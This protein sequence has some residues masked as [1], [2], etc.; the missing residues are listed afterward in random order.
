M[1]RLGLSGFIAVSRDF[2]N[3]PDFRDGEM[4]Q[5]EAF[6]WML[7]EAA[8]KPR[9]KRI[10]TV[11]LELQRGQLAASTRFLAKAWGWSEPRV[12]RY[13]DM[14]K[15]RRTIDAATDA[16]VTV[17]TIRN[18]D[19]YQSAASGADAPGDEK[20]THH[21]RTTDANPEQGNNTTLMTG[22]RECVDA[23]LEAAGPAMADPAKSPGV[24][25][26]SE[27]LSWVG[28]G[29]DLQADI[30]PA[31]RA[32][33]ARASPGSV[34][35]WAYFREAVMEA[36]ARREAG[37]ET[38]EINHDQQRS[39]SKSENTDRHR[40]AFASALRGYSGRSEDGGLEPGDD[41]EY[42]GVQVIDG[43]SAG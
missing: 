3:D 33:S 32:R 38:P 30:L 13:F 6:L 21:R 19:K 17:I 40:S 18:Y 34:R 24:L 36:K 26:P 4:T 7:A 43:R 37:I 1:G 41:E 20:S 42:P 5:R 31:I 8:W 23:A 2:W 12:R 28:S 29:A 11:V 35:S 27:I 25:M 15:N 10:K 9:T 14:L 22:A 39:G 16:G